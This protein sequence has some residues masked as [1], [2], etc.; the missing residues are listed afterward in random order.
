MLLIPGIK[1]KTSA[2]KR[3][4]LPSRIVILMSTLNIYPA[5]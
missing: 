5:G 4:E 1:K 2:E 3:K